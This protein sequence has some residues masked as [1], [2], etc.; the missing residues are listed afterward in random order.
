MYDLYKLEYFLKLARAGSFVRAAEALSISQPALTRSI[1]SLERSVGMSLFN[2][3]KSG[4]TLTAVGESFRAQA[5]DLLFRAANVEHNMRQVVKG[6]RGSARFGIAPASASAFLPGLLEHL[7]DH[8]PDVTA[9]VA[10][11]SVEEMYD[12][13]LDED[14]EFFVARGTTELG[15]DP[16]IAA[17][18]LG[19]ARA[20][21]YVR[22]GH[23]LL[24]R[25]SVTPAD[26]Q[27]YRMAS[28]TAWNENV[29]SSGATEL[30]P[31]LATIEV[32]NYDLLARLA[33]SSD[34]VLIASFGAFHGLTELPIAPH[35]LGLPNSK[36]S[37][38]TLDG[39]TQGPASNLLQ[40]YL[41]DQFAALASNDEI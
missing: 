34:T 24:G 41:S 33:A 19:E 15:A 4:V 40:R 31:L 6:T 22:A 23:P 30:L 35:D 3:S 11:S 26:L 32:D 38:F 13:L 10:I 36:V 18:H 1:Q 25:E 7:H 8:L 9:H 27:R 17:R 28:G 20:R 39:R 2:R 12:Q 16:R 37:I 29:H 14:L 5:E 21:F